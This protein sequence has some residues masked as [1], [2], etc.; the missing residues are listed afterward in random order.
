M[1]DHPSS[2]SYRPHLD[3]VRALAVIAVFIFHAAPTALPGGF[4]GVDAFFVLSGFLITSILLGKVGRGE[5]WMADF[6]SR[7]VKR[8]L[9]AVLLVLLAVVV[10][11]G[12]YEPPSEFA[13]RLSEVRATIFY[14]ANWNL[15]SSSDDYF[16]ESFSVSPLRHMWSLAVE[17]QF[18]FVWP[19]VLTGLIA[20]FGRRDRLQIPVIAAIVVSAY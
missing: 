1:S 7:R 16:A 17:E 5:P 13:Q 20:L 11:A 15:I 4:I 3:G 6:Y 19:L 2:F 18:Y 8:L 12:V 9:P 14:F 10:V